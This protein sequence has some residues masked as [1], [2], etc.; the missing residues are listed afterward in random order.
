MPPPTPSSPRSTRSRASPPSSSSAVSPSPTTTA[1]VSPS[2]S[3]RPASIPRDI[4]E[5]VV[6]KSGPVGKKIEKVADLDKLKSANDVVFVAVLPEESKELKNYLTVADSMDDLTF[7]YIVD[8]NVAEDLSL[9]EHSLVVYKKY[10][11][12]FSQFEGEFSVE[13]IHSFAHK[14]ELPLVIPFN[15]KN[16][17][18]IFNPNSGIDSQCIIFVEEGEE[19]EEDMNTFRKVSAAHQGD[20]FF[21]NIPIENTRLM[22]Y[23]GVSLSELPAVVMVKSL[24]TGMKKYKFEGEFNEDELNK[25]VVDYKEGKLSPYLKSEA[26]P[27]EQNEPV[28]VV[29]GKTF[30]EIALDPSKNVFVLFYAP[31]CGHCKALHP[32]YKQ[33][34]EKLAD[35]DDILIT[36]MDATAN[37]VDHPEVQIRGF[38]TL[39]F[40]QANTNKVFSYEGDRTLDDLMKFVLDHSV[41]P[42][43]TEETN[44]EL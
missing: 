22:D 14:H 25:F 42:E 8:I 44:E 10:D 36:K 28:Y 33:L 2:T 21:V 9:N 31:W 6:R 18:K 17:R 11:E 27:S 1:V 23:F 19:G 12:E 43:V 32:T 15:Q 13:G 26:I 37:E 5:Y 24:N 30:N 35:R 4:V 34:A 7:A 39:K 41:K 40:F 16:A 20:A 3:P 29:V 38:P